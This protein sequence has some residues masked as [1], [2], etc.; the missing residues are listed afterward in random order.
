MQEDG[1]KG[2]HIKLAFRRLEAAKA[3][4][5]SARKIDYLI[6]DGT[7]KIIRHKGT[8]LIPTS[9]MMKMLEVR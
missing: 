3:L 2:S 6:A 9:E 4:G 8:I 1:K 7:L 5:I